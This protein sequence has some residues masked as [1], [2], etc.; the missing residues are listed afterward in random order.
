MDIP[1]RLW[2]DMQTALDQALARIEMLDTDP[3]V[4]T[5]QILDFGHRALQSAAALFAEMA[6]EAAA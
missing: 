6:R 2:D 3:A 4:V 5:R 1:R